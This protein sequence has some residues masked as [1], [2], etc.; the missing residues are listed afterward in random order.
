MAEFRLGFLADE[1][2]GGEFVGFTRGTE[3][4]LEMRD[5]GSVAREIF[6]NEAGEVEKE[7]RLS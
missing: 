7:E 2:A 3:D 4:H 6:L 5:L 1:V